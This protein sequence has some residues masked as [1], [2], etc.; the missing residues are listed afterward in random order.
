M[1]RIAGAT[2][3]IKEENMSHVRIPRFPPKVK[4]FTSVSAAA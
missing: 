2:E 4:D 1:S 3:L